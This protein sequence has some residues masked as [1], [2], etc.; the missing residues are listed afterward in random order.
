MFTNPYDD[1]SG[2][3]V[4]GLALVA[5]HARF[6]RD[7]ALS[8]L[9]ASPGVLDASYSRLPRLELLGN[10]SALTAGW[11]ERTRAQPPGGRE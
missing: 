2:R 8:L 1:I 7:A 4:L 3:T 9:A 11:R 6:G 5:H 10:S